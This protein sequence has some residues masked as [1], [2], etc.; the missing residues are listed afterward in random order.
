LMSGT[1]ADTFEDMLEVSGA[2]QDGEKADLKVQ[3]RDRKMQLNVSTQRSPDL[4]QIAS[5]L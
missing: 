5:Y 4:P 1:R 2:V 3:G